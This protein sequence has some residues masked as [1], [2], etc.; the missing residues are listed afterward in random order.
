MF[1]ASISSST[2]KIA[3]IDHAK[4][5]SPLAIES[6]EMHEKINSRR[7]YCPYWSLLFFP[8]PAGAISFQ[9]ETDGREVIMPKTA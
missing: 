5:K 4:S 2:Q 3:R 6:Y 9:L 8:P 7:S 1:P